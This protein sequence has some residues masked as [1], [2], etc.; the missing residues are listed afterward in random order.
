MYGVRGN[1]APASL[2]DKL[3]RRYARLG[4]F[5]SILSLD[6]IWIDLLI[7]HAAGDGPQDGGRGG[8]G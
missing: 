8:D 4:Y 1:E 7:A 2:G 3:G 6:D 5:I